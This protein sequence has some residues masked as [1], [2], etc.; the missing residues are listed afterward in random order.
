MTLDTFD[1]D[2]MPPTTIRSEN[3]VMTIPVTHVGIENVVLSA[4]DIEFA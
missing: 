3:I 4:P 2:F 1:M